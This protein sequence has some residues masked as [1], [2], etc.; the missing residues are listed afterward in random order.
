M[1]A[2]KSM[3]LNKKE[4]KDAELG[5]ESEPVEFP[6]GLRLQLDDEAVTKLGTP[7]LRVGDEVLVAAKATVS[8]VSSHES[9][10][11]EVDLNISLQI[12]DMA[13]SE[14]STDTDRAAK[15]FPGQGKS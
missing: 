14:E 12:T 13:L 11:G 15:M 4:Q 10:E 7:S 3:K 6:W 8:S 2:L 1:P 5:V 9:K